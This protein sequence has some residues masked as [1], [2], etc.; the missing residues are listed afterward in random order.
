VIRRLQ[1]L[2]R[3]YWRLK[4]SRRRSISL[5]F[6]A[7]DLSRV[8]QGESVRSVS[9]SISQ[10]IE[11]VA[12]S[13]SVSPVRMYSPMIYRVPEYRLSK[14]PSLLHRS[15]IGNC[16]WFVL[17]FVLVSVI[18][19]IFVLEKGIS[20]TSIRIRIPRP[21]HAVAVHIHDAAQPFDSVII[22]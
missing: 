12:P 21:V 9:F 19:V 5:L 6:I 18:V 20:T 15:S 7:L 2:R 3:A 8:P 16:P 10:N 4:D 13:V 11:N 22:R 1:R 17:L 14:G